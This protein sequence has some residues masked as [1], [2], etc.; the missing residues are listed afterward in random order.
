MAAD[1]FPGKYF[2]DRADARGVWFKVDKEEELFMRY[3]A[4]VFVAVLGF[5]GIGIC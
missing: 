4:F 3:F 1:P 5:V 2:F